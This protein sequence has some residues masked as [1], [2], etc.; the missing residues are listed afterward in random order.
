MDGNWPGHQMID[1]T[2]LESRFALESGLAY[3]DSIFSEPTEESLA[4]VERIRQVMVQI[5]TTEADFIMLYYFKNKRQTEIANIFG[6]S[7]PTVCYR[8]KRAAA[9]IRFLLELPEVSLAEI[10]S[11]L[12]EQDIKPLNIRIMLLMVE[13]TCQSAVAA[14][15]DLTQGKVR[16]RYV[17]TVDKLRGVPG[18]EPFIELFDLISA[19]LVILREVTNR[20]NKQSDDIEF[21]LD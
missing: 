2:E 20:N 18:S 4:R 13:L 6:C 7:Q 16:H 10:E 12:V 8:L 9:R 1:P 3:M 19:N 11:F 15:L 21:I 5:P 14:E 17:T